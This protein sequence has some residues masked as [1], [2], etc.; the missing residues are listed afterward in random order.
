MVFGIEMA[1]RSLRTERFAPRGKWNTTICIAVVSCHN[2]LANVQSMLRQPHLVP[3]AVRPSYSCYSV[4]SGFLLPAFGRCHQHSTH[5]DFQHGPQRT[6][7][8]LAHVLLPVGSII[9]I[10]TSKLHDTAS[11]V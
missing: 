7:L 4:H 9:D 10:R 11:K 8:S 1:C 6:N 3:H 5:A 2:R